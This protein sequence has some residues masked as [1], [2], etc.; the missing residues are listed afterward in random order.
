M[1]VGVSLRLRPS[2]QEARAAHCAPVED[3][4]GSSSGREESLH[5]VTWRSGSDFIFT[6]IWQGTGGSAEMNWCCA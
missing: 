1:S 3:S 4:E 5:R 6:I 2:Y